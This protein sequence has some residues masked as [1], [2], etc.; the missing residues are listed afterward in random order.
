MNKAESKYYNTA[1]RMDEALLTL[2]EKKDFEYITVKEI[3]EKAGVNRST[4]YLHYETVCDLL[5]ECVE[6]INR[7]FSE[8]FGDRQKSVSENIKNRNLKDLIFITPEYLKPCLEFVKENKLLFK[9]AMLRPSILRVEKTFADLFRDVFSPVLDC[10]HY[11]D[12][13]K[14]YVIS[15]YVSGLIAIVSEWIKHD[16]LDSTEKIIE[17]CMHCVLQSGKENH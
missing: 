14:P 3:C 4:F 10:F 17:I 12:E 2:L 5:D 16:C 9:V 6:Y 1:V 13:S 15:F 11:S 7:K 8:K